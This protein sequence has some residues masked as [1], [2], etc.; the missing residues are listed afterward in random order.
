[1]LI[2]VVAAAAVA[3]AATAHA[4]THQVIEGCSWN[5]S[6]DWVYTDGSLCRTTGE[7][8]TT[9]G[10]GEPAC[11]DGRVAVVTSLRMTCLAPAGIATGSNIRLV[12]STTD[13]VCTGNRLGMTPDQIAQGLQRAGG[14]TNYWQAWRETWIPIVEGDCGDN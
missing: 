10:A 11:A 9:D 14:Q 7:D 13:T 5:G 1:M 6:T 2:A 3:G 4:D 8:P 12:D